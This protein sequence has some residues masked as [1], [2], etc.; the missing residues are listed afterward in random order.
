MEYVSIA[1]SE[2]GS[3]TLKAAQS[4]HNA[5]LCGLCITLSAEGS[6]QLTDTNDNALTGAIALAAK[7]PLVLPVTG[8][9]HLRVANAGIK[10]VSSTGAATGWAVIAVR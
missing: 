10:L 4:G 6:V 9:D 5:C 8:V 2:A 3:Q 1:Q 7:T